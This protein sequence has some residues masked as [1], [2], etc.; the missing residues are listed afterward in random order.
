MHKFFFDAIPTAFKIVQCIMLVSIF[1]CTSQY[2][3][4][5]DSQKK[6]E[7]ERIKIGEE[8]YTRGQIIAD[9][10]NVAFSNALWN[11]DAEKIQDGGFSR[12][13]DW[14]AKKG[15]ILNDPKIRKSYEE[16]NII[17]PWFAEYIYRPH[18]LPQHNV[19]HKWDKEI[20][21]GVG[22]PAYPSNNNDSIGSRYNSKN[23]EK[24]H[25]LIAEEVKKFSANLEDVT[26]MPVK[27]IPANDPRD[28][29]KNYARVRII[30]TNHWLRRGWGE[31]MEEFWHPSS[32]ERMLLGGV[33]FESSGTQM[34]AYLLP[35]ENN[36][37]GLV[38]C[39][40]RMDMGE[41]TFRSFVNECLLRALGLPGV[42]KIQTNSLV[43]NWKS[44]LDSEGKVYSMTE[45]DKLIARILYCPSI[46]SGMDKNKIVQIL[47]TSNQCFNN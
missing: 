1:T 21:I 28:N 10:L 5:Q 4:A 7:P 9:F 41:G 12:M 25:S 22:W 26:N 30:P 24:Y 47:S 18:G 17:A 37:L 42:S 31:I 29:T 27:F 34:D 35:K 8:Y 15:I 20:S 45:H 43:S 36:Q 44:L 39:K 11:E 2:V 6:N 23:S 38:V 14:R 33:L 19:I 13:I 3:L 32:N 46:K 16:L 40:V